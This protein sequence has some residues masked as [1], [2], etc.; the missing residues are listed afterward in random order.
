MSR[1]HFKRRDIQ[2]NKTKAGRALLYTLIFSFFYFFVQTNA[3]SYELKDDLGNTW[4]IDTPALRIISLAPSF[5][6]SLFAIGAG[7]QIVGVTQ[8]SDF[9]EAAKK[10][11]RVGALNLQY[12]TIVSLHPDVL[13]GDPALTSKSLEKLRSLN[14]KAVALRTQK[15]EDI[16]ITLQKLGEITGHEKEAQQVST[17]M[18]EKMKKLASKTEGLPRPRVFL[19]VWD[20]P[21]MTAGSSTFLGE[22]IQMAGGDNIAGSAA[23][24]WGLISEEVVIQKDPEV[25][26]LLTSKKKDFLDRPAWKGTSAAKT[27]RIY[28]LNRDLFSHPS[29]RIVDALQEL[30][31]IIH[32]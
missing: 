2:L 18:L 23:E 30:V 26:L 14:L 1:P 19:E 4:Q 24:A 22:L 21:L 7:S 27:G 3:F 31:A 28:E 12:E 25:L 13:I 9:P 17:E 16:P 5:T 20:S 11:P 29:P 32:P 8:Y 6:E 10:L 15:I